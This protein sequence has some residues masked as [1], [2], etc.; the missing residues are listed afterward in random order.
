MF[1]HTKLKFKRFWV[2][3]RL[4]FRAYY[5]YRRGQRD[6]MYNLIADELFKIGGVY[7]K[8]L[9][10]VILQSWLMQRWRNDKKLDI[11]E[12]ID[13][14][15]LDI[16][17][18][19]AANL[20][21]KIKRIK[22]VSDEPF[23]VGS[24]GHVYEAKLDTGQKVIIKA[25]SPKIR[26]T[27]EFDLMLL[28]WFWYFHLRSIRFNKGLNIKLIFK[29]FKNQTR[30][31]IDY[32]NEAK[33]AHQQYL[34]YKKHPLLIIPRTYTDLCTKEIIVQEY[35]E[36][37]PITQLL[38]LKEKKPK[39]NLKTYV[40]KELGSDLVKQLQ[41]L[42]YELIWATFHHEKVMGDPHPGNVI[43]LKK[44]KVAL[45]DFGISAQ[46]SRDPIAYLRLIKAYHALSRGKL[47]PQDIFSAGLRFFGRDL[48]LALAK[49]SYLAPPTEEKMVNLNKELAKV[50]QNMF[51][52]TFSQK[53]IEN[54]TKNPKAL[55][56]FDRL[57]NKNN[58][59]GFNIKI[60]DTDVLRTLITWTSLVDL[61]GLYAQ[62]MKHVYA[63]VIKEVEAVY[64][65]LKSINDPEISHNQALNIVFKWLERVATRDP[66]LFKNLMAKMRLRQKIMEENKPGKK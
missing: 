64:P 4:L 44:N 7:V 60:Q 36:G 27:F 14:Q 43:L 13:R 16:K 52:D 12:M 23:A 31:E 3:S 30:R 5:F 61:L 19:L 39:T 37:I 51:E 49:I 54:L 62:V 21:K 6:E 56:V 20:G 1:K 32:V 40:K 53:D 22:K 48:Y 55:V 45:I 2:I 65:D 59:F 15:K 17:K 41:T 10:G 63:K 50:V 28:K 11:F 46:S 33:F 26:E 9:Q 18:L 8:F 34:T 35:I 47:D 42:G 66:G 24:F 38:R 29:D 25:L 57:A 58:R